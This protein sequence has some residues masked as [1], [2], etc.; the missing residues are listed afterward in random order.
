[1]SRHSSTQVDCAAGVL[2][3]DL[4]AI[5]GTILTLAVSSLAGYG[6]EMFRSRI[7]ERIFAVLLL[8]LIDPVRRAHGAAL[9]A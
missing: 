6:F 3:F 2:E 1:M 8:M 7:R 9:R 4:I 5:V